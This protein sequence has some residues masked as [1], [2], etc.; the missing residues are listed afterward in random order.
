MDSRTSSILF[1]LDLNVNSKLI[2]NQYDTSIKKIE[3]SERGDKKKTYK[4]LKQIVSESYLTGSL[5]YG[6]NFIM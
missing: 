5:S 4:K 1:N 3:E 2:A 6:N